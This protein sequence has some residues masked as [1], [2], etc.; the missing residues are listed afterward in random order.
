M[1]HSAEYQKIR[2]H[3]KLTIFQFLK[4]DKKKLLATNVG[5]VSFNTYFKKKKKKEQKLSKQLSQCIKLNW[6]PS[7]ILYFSSSSLQIELLPHTVHTMAERPLQ[8]G[9]AGGL[10]LET[11]TS[12]SG[13]SHYCFIRASLSRFLICQLLL[14]LWFSCFS[15][16]VM[17]KSYV[18]P[19]TEWSPPGSS[20]HGVL[21][22]RILEW[23]AIS[24]S[25]GSF[26]TWDWTLDPSIG[27]RIS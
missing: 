5:A 23:A 7:N 11:K 25:R 24:F 17:S 15:H 22:A 9:D 21:Q 4:M 3:C 20:V 1:N 14:H 13:S 2:Q 18:T 19:W 12:T 16:S 26:W 6:P 8:A 10:I 27:R